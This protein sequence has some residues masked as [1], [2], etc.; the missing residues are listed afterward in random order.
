MLYIDKKPPEI[1]QDEGMMLDG[2]TVDGIPYFGEPFRG[3]IRIYQDDRLSMTIKR[4]MLRETKPEPSTDGKQRYK[5]WPLLQ[6]H[7]VDV[8]KVVEGWMIADERRKGKLTRAELEQLTFE[9]GAK[10]KNEILVGD[11]KLRVNAI[12]LH[13]HALKDDSSPSS[14]PKSR[15][16]S[17]HL[18]APHLSAEIPDSL[19]AA[20]FRNRFFN[21]GAIP[22]LPLDGTAPVAPRRA[23]RS[24][25]G[26]AEC[27]RN[28]VFDL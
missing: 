4:P 22:P 18:S 20:P 3:G 5:L 26:T 8:N 19:F 9:I 10:E 25:W 21:Y 15:T 24:D 2:K 11:G 13:G 16:D 28:R 1:V 7:G 23:R 27:G 6:S 14:A 12:A 17:L